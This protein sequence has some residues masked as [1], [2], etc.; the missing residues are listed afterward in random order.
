MIMVVG[1]TG[2][3]GAPLV[4]MLA[5]AGEEVTAVSRRITAAPPGVVVR[6]GDLATLDFEGVSAVFLMVSGAFVPLDDVLA[7]AAAAGVRKVVALSSQGVATGRHPAVLEDSVR[8]SGLE[9]TLLR[10][11]AFAS[12]T[13]QWAESVRSAR[14]VVAPFA[15]VA[16][17]VVDPEDIA[18]VAAAALREDGHAGQAYTLTGPAPITPREQ[19]AAIGAAVGEPVRFTSQTREEARAMLLG[20]MPAEVADVTLDILGAPTPAEQQVSPDVARVLGRPPKPFA[21]WAALLAGAFK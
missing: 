16:L 3:V 10:P 1:A 21:E 20:F 8:R 4:R 2:N 13:L 17:P 19:A 12:N 14:E 11:G 6:Q 9:W 15:D 7:R 5:E 18:A